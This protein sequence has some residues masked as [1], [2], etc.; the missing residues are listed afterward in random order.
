MAPEKLK[1]IFLSASIPFPDRHPKYFETADIIAIRDAVIALATIVIP[2]YRLIWGGHPSVTPIIYHIMKKMN[3]NIQNHMTIYQSQ[4]F[5]DIFPIDNENFEN[6]LLTKKLEDQDSSLAH[7][8]EKMFSENKF[9]A[10]IFIGGM[11][12]I[13]IEFNLFQKNQPEALILPIASTG[14]ASKIIYEKLLDK[15]F[16][17][18]KLINEYSYTNLFQE[19]LIDKIK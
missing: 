8:R 9:E 16:K 4:Y 14:G 13:E 17:N 6:I 18:E 7:M 15:K 3:I 11:E 1:N 2:K 12:G 10:G 19:L 5:K